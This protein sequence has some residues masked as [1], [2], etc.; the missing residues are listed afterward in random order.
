MQIHLEANKVL[1]HLFNR[2]D[3]LTY[4]WVVS[5]SDL[6]T[7]LDLATILLLKS[8]EFLPDGVL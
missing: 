3:H 5:K 7:F 4:L 2:I 6:L 8:D 1:C